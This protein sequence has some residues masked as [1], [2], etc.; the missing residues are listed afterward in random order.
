MDSI[1]YP[2]KLGD[3]GRFENLNENIFISVFHI[4]KREDLPR[5]N[6]KC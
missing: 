2:V 3:I 1:S 4:Y 5:E 6:N